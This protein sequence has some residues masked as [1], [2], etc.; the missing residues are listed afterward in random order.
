MGTAV[1]EAVVAVVTVPAGVQL[2]LEIPFDYGKLDTETRIFIRQ[3]TSE[4]Y[5]LMRDVVSRVMD[6]GRKLIEVREAIYANPDGGTF[7]AW[8]RTEFEWSD[9]AAYQYMRVAEKFADNPEI[10]NV[11][12]SALYLL[13]SPRVPE[14]VR[15]DVLDKAAG[16]EVVTRKD[17]VKA[18]KTQKKR[19]ERKQTT[20]PLEAPAAGA[21]SSLPD[22]A[23]SAAADPVADRMDELL[24]K[25]TLTPEEQAE[26]VELAAKAAAQ[27]RDAEEIAER[28]RC[29]KACVNAIRK[30]VKRCRVM[31]ERY[32]EMEGGTVTTRNY[33]GQAW[34]AAERELQPVVDAEAK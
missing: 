22:V 24:S 6:L 23:Q 29:V 31:V 9:S 5:G 20:L 26:S 3:K 15:Q 10:G 8:L 25:E 1:A 16:G 21:D 27:T 33:L 7:N 4:I 17:V 34:D 30:A 14:E 13:A 28:A 19:Q 18:V 2:Q 12:P 32:P 11:A